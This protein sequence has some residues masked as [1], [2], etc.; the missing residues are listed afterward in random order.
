MYK[1]LLISTVLVVMILSFAGCAQTSNLEGG[2]NATEYKR[3]S[4]EDAKKML[5]ENP[6]AVLLDVRTDSE[7][8]EQHIEGAL[9]IPDYEIEDKAAEELPEKDALILVYCR[10]GNRSKTASKTLIS[11]GYTNVYDFGGIN[12]WPY[13][14]VK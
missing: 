11:M 1:K 13:D 6:D 2:G 8:K 9:L 14:V 5:D 3:I 7:Y 12:S 10:S 4:A